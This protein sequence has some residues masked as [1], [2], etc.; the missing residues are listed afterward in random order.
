MFSQPS[1]QPSFFL[2]APLCRC[3]LLFPGLGGLWSRGS[4]SCFL[5]VPELQPREHE[6]SRGCWCGLVLLLPCRACLGMQQPQQG[7]GKP[8]GAV[9]R[10]FPKHVGGRAPGSLLCELSVLG[11]AWSW[12]PLA[13]S[14]LLSSTSQLAPTRCFPTAASLSSISTCPQWPWHYF[15]LFIS[16]DY[17]SVL[18]C[19]CYC[20]IHDHSEQENTFCLNVEILSSAQYP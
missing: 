2:R 14:V 11:P 4:C 20:H 19:L 8:G 1:S 9:P 12:E 13:S 3:F 17:C 16:T 5:C 18:W 10:V 15:L 7:Q 6:G